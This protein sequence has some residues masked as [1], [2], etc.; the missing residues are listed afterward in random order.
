M[1]V[2]RL[3]RSSDRIP[4]VALRQPITFVRWT[5]LKPNLSGSS[6]MLRECCVWG[7]STLNYRL[8]PRQGGGY[9][10]FWAS[11]VDSGRWLGLVGAG[12]A[13]NVA[14]AVVVCGRGAVRPHG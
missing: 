8:I 10:R 11:G 9:A 7:P 6:G 13:I 3:I 4:N 14:A 5:V 2:F 12:V 1:P